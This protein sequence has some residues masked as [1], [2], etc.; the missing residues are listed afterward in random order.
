MM[1]IIHFGRHGNLNSNQDEEAITYALR[2]LGH[3]VLPVHERQ[4]VDFKSTGCEM[5]LFHNWSDRETWK[6]FKAGCK[7]FWCF[8]M[9]DCDDETLRARCLH[10]KQWMA[11][12]LPHADIGLCTDGD[13]VAEGA[14][15]HGLDADKLVWLPQGFDERLQPAPPPAR[16]QIIDLL[17]TAG[18]FRRGCER[19]S[20][21]DEMRQ[22]YGPR[23]HHVTRGHYGADLAN[24]VTHSKIVLAPDGPGTDRYHSNRV[25]LLSGL[26]SFLLHPFFQGVAAHYRSD[27]EIKFYHDRQHLHELIA[28]YLDDAKVGHRAWQGAAA[29]ERTLQSHTYRHRVA[30][31]LRVVRERGL[32]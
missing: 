17:L 1:R 27:H 30:E 12:T 13:W 9:I 5:L 10:R 31:L 14:A 7:V 29:R 16:G 11:E 23:L 24:L 21:I 4:A 6:D 26:G 25:Y 3:Q 2:E 20:F 8:D 32:A 19:R 18:K 15:R 28:V 22:T